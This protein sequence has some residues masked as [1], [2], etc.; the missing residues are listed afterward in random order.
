MRNLIILAGIPGCGKSTWAE[1]MLGSYVILS[2][3]SIRK[4]LA[5]SLTE[6][7]AQNLNSQVFREFYA[8]IEE[9]L[10]NGWSVVAD[11]TNLTR[12]SRQDLVN[13]ANLTG[14]NAHLVLFKNVQQAIDRNM[15]REEDRVVPEDVMEKMVGKYRDTLAELPQEQ[16]V[17]IT[18]IESVS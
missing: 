9:Y 1:N 10:K 15:A 18:R 4:R 12:K 2:T 14:A 3:D 7:H 11:A 8:L 5:G 16:Y 6:A 17:S 13:I